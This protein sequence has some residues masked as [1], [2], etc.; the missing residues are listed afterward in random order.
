[1]DAYSAFLQT[2]AARFAAIDPEW[3]RKVQHANTCPSSMLGHLAWSRG[4][5]YWSTSWTETE[6][7]ELI[8]TTPLRLRLR[9]TRAAIESAV[10]AFGG[11]LFITEWWQLDPHATRMTAYVQGS[12]GGSIGLELERDI[13]TALLAVIEREGRKSVSWYLTIGVAGITGI[14]V[15]ARCRITSLWQH[16]GVQLG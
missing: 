5:D 2:A 6:K 1:M 3:P 4:L 16:S 13:Q 12:V 14:A 10:E 15:D 8:R 9:G 11:E 7:R